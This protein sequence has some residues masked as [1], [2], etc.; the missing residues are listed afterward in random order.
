MKQVLLFLSLLCTQLLAQAQPQGFH[1][2]AVARDGNQLI[3]NLSLGVKIRLIDKTPTGQT[4][5]EE[6]HE[7]KTNEVGVFNLEIG[8]GRTLS[9][10]FDSVAWENETIFLEV[11]ID[12]EGGS[13]YQSMGMTR[14]AE[15]ALCHVC[16]GS[17]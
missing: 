11:S 10:E 16:K 17:R 6:I 12:P 14:F 1:Y 2:Q 9:G 8:M 5:Y 13:N 15:C 7:V 3:I 4:L